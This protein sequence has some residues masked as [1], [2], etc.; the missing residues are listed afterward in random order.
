MMYHLEKEIDIPEAAFIIDNKSYSVPCV[1]QIW[2]KK[3]YNREL[4][5]QVYPIH[6]EFVKKDDNPT[7]SIRR[8][9]VYAGNV[10]TDCDKSI[11]SHYF[12][13]VNNE[14]HISRIIENVSKDSFVNASNTVGP[15]S[16]SK[17]E[18]IEIINEILT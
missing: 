10:S 13:R 18:V 6:F 17:G 7:L 4:P 16:I 8:V 12:I 11:Q 15:K 5:T 1:F 14:E 9:G 2:V 3:T